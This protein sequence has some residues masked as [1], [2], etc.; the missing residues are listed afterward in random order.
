MITYG[1]TLHQAVT[2]MAAAVWSKSV[3]LLMFGVILAFSPCKVYPSKEGF[4]GGI[5]C[6]G[7]IRFPVAPKIPGLVPQWG[8]LYIR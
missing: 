3:Q 7:R 8:V 6:K 4:H 1:H 2:P 5:G